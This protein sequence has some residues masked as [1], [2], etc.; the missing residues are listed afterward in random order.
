MKRKSSIRSLISTMHSSS[1]LVLLLLVAAL[2]AFVAA[3]K[4]QNVYPWGENPNNRYRMYWKDSTNVLSD[5]DQFKAL[6][7]KVH[8]C[9]WSE[10][11]LGD[12]YDD[13][14]ENHDGDENCECHIVLV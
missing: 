1:S 5:L 2:S 7:I 12:N 14:G 3:D 8:G 11:G 9:V 6:Y 10:Y 4:D 13:D